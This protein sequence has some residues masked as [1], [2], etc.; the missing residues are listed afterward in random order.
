MQL[1]MLEIITATYKRMKPPSY[2]VL[3]TCVR[4]EFNWI[5]NMAWGAYLNMN[6]IQ[7]QDLTFQISVHVRQQKFQKSS[8][9]I[10]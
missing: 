2:T 1:A 7:A 4:K 3:A 5:K 9:L 8:P 10:V 6:T